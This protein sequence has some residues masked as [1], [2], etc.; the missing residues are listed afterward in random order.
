MINI[1]SNFVLFILRLFSWIPGVDTQAAVW[2]VNALAIFILIAGLEIWLRQA[3]PGKL[4]AEGGWL[5]S[6]I[7]VFG[8]AFNISSDWKLWLIGI[9]LILAALWKAGWL[10]AK[11]GEKHTAKGTIHQVLNK[12][13]TW[14][15]EEELPH[16]PTPKRSFGNFSKNRKEDKEKDVPK[17]DAPL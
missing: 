8:I 5:W 16:Q 15:D 6:I 17:W 14:L 13:N 12:I 2:G 1:L 9:E 10:G 11:S 3:V 4:F 7:F